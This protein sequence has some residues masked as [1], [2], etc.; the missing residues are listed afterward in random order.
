[1]AR[2]CR[3]AQPRRSSGASSRAVRRSPAAPRRQARVSGLSRNRSRQPSPAAT[4]TAGQRPPG[5]ER[6]GRPAA[7]RP[8]R[9]PAPRRPARA[10]CGSRRPA[11]RPV[12]AGTRRGRRRRG[13]RRWPAPAPPPPAPAAP[14]PSQ[15]ARP[16]R[17]RGRGGRAGPEVGV[18]EGPDRHA[19][20]LVVTGG[21][22]AVR[23]GVGLGPGHG[24]PPCGA[25]RRP[26]PGP[27][28]VLPPARCGLVAGPAGGGRLGAGRDAAPRC[29][30]RSWRC[31]GGPGPGRWPG[32]RAARR[33]A[34]RARAA[35]GPAP[36]RGR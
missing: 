6:A 29:G 13:G 26:A 1:M 27:A 7:R 11:R 33:P 31:A 30:W 4:V 10:G 16:G 8:R 34:G 23:V 3:T 12:G 24:W 5:R 35:P 22:E 25:S 17:G 28:G 20:R 36:G 9:R 19:R 14:L 2:S 15:Q 32:G 21:P 18:A